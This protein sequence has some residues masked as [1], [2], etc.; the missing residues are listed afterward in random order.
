MMTRLLSYVLEHDLGLSPNPFGGYCTLA[1]CKFSH[2]RRRNVVELAKIGDWVVGTGG[3]SQRSSGHGTLIYAMKI[4]DKLSLHDYFNDER[5]RGRADNH[6]ED[7]ARTDRFALISTDFFYFGSN[8]VPI[9]QEFARLEKKGPGFRDRFDEPFITRF[10]EWIRKSPPG[11]QGE[12]C[13]D[14]L[15]NARGSAGESSC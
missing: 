10:E 5:F 3:A 4:T 9:P 6:A 7:A 11:L 14:R 2:S 8:A 15:S 13:G 12:P 1:H